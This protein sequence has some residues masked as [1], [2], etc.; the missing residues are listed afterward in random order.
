MAINDK[1]MCMAVS[2][3]IRNSFNTIGWEDMLEALRRLE[4]QPNLLKL[5][6]SYFSNGSVW[7]DCS[8]SVGNTLT[9]NV[10]CGA[11]QG[12]LVGPLLWDFAYDRVLRV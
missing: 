5:F 3:D 8:T 1:S 11:P 2:L 12:L 6:S 4:I 7:I 9:V 10:T